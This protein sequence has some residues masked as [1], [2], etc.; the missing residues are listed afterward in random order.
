MAVANALLF[1][2]GKQSVWKLL[3]STHFNAPSSFSTVA[4]NWRGWDTP[5]KSVCKVRKELLCV[6]TKNKGSCF[7]TANIMVQ[8]NR[9]IQLGIDNVGQETCLF[10]VGVTG[11]CSDLRTAPLVAV[12]TYIQ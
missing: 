9:H 11:K 8:V 1:G 3:N 10:R 5:L 12:H 2:C 7:Q 6:G 4:Q